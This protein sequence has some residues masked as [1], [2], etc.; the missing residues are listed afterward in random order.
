MYAV[1]LIPIPLPKT[2]C[3][4][5]VH[6]TVVQLAEMSCDT[7]THTPARESYTNCEPYYSVIHNC[8]TKYLGQGHGYDRHSSRKSEGE[9]AHS[10]DQDV[11]PSITPPA[12][13]SRAASKEET[14]Q[15]STPTPRLN[16]EIHRGEPLV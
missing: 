5:V 12:G 6:R 8:C 2:V 15:E 14:G 3:T 16:P 1:T 9:S 13:S 7:H 11:A 4:T 10:C